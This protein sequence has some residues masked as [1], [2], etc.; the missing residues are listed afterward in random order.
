[1]NADV[2][3]SL[4]TRRAIRFHVHRRVGTYGIATKAMLTQA[5][6]LCREHRIPVTQ[7][8]AEQ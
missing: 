2:A 1:M 4:F 6:C 5:L 3:S 7:L 8:H